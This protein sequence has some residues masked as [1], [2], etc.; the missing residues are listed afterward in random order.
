MTRWVF[1]VGVYAIA[2]FPP[3]S[4]FFSK[5]EILVAAWASHVPGHTWLYGIGM[6]TAGL[7]AFY[8]FRLWYLTFCGESRV[9]SDVLSHVKDP[10]GFVLNPLWVLAFFSVTAGLVGLPQIWGDLIGIEESNSLANFLKP[11]FAAGEPH[12]IAHST[13]Y[14]MA[15]WAVAIALSGTALAWLLYIKKPGVPDRIAATLS[16]LYRTLLNKY[17]IDEL[18]DAVIVRPLVV[19]SDRVLYRIV[20]A[21]LIDGIGANGTAYGIRAVA[22]NG[23]KYAQSGLAQSYIFFMIVGAVAIV[24][25]LL[26]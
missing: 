8:M 22:A 2:G 5:D 3:F 14:W 13:E 11:A 21:G 12:H 7:T 15:F 26:R 19:F 6:L 4:G 23:L 10:N 25:Y 9:P 1:F 16:G 17:Y 24:G 18:Y 20:D